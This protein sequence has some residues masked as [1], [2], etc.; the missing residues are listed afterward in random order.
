MS[1]WP[2]KEK[3]DLVEVSVT[4][5]RETYEKAKAIAA[6]PDPYR[7]NMGEYAGLLDTEEYLGIVLDTYFERIAAPAGK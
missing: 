4:I 3:Q 7:Y 6:D 2:G 1:D 5:A